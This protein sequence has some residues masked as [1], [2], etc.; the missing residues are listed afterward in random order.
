[1]I[2]TSPSAAAGFLTF[3]STNGMIIWLDQNGRNLKEIEN[4]ED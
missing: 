4:D 2:N 1:M 3:A